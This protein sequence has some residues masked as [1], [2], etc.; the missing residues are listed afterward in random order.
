MIF[1]I[2]PVC[3]LPFTTHVICQM[4]RLCSQQR[5]ER[6]REFLPPPQALFCN[7]VPAHRMVQRAEQ[8]VAICP[9]VMPHVTM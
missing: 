5:R 8:C 2:S 7:A 3:W 6:S 4:A 9:G 1:I